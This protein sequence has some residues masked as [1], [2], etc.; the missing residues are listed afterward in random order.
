MFI[1]LIASELKVMVK[2][3]TPGEIPV[4]K[5]DEGAYFLGED[6]KVS[7]CN[8]KKVYVPV[9][10]L[11]ASTQL[12]SCVVKN[13]KID[14]ELDNNI[15]GI[16]KQNLDRFEIGSKKI[17]LMRYLESIS[18]STKGPVRSVNITYGMCS[19]PVPNSIKFILSL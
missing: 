9:F 1:N 18:I 5:S 19:L 17:I 10:P 11:I 16:L 8:K 15:L 6:Y 13:E 3:L 7:F 12:T 4:I 2:R 14:K